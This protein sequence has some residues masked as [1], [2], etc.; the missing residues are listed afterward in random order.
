MGELKYDTVSSDYWMD[1]KTEAQIQSE[2]DSGRHNMKK[3]SDLP[4][5]SQ[6]YLKFKILSARNELYKALILL[7]AISD[8]AELVE[9]LQCIRGQLGVWLEDKE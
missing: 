8:T 2:L 7:N 6:E 9:W 5:Q 4:T 3:F 1:A